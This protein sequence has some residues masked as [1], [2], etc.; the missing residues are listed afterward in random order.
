MGLCINK[1]CADA[2]L[3]SVSGDI[4]MVSSNKKDDSGLDVTTYVLPG[5]DGASYPSYVLDLLIPVQ[6]NDDSHIEYSAFCTNLY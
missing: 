3:A 5:A 4:L 2:T 6:L 1:L